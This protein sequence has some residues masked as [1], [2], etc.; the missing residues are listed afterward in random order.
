MLSVTA[1]HILQALY[2]DVRRV[3]QTWA[4]DNM[5]EDTMEDSSWKYQLSYMP[6]LT[7]LLLADCGRGG[8]HAS[9]DRKTSK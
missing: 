4:E 8:N 7:R 5:A 9:H 1:C 6:I 3:E 2:L